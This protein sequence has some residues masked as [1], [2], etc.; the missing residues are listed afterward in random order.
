MEP[1]TLPLGVVTQTLTALFCV[2][3]DG[4]LLEAERALD[5]G[6]DPSQDTWTTIVTAAREGRIE[7]IPAPV[8]LLRT[9]GAPDDLE[10]EAVRDCLRRCASLLPEVVAE[11]ERLW[12]GTDGE[13]VSQDVARTAVAMA[14][15]RYQQLHAG[16]QPLPGERERNC[17]FYEVH[18]GVRRRETLELAA[19]IRGMWPVIL[20]GENDLLAVA[21]VHRH[22]A[23]ESQALGA[24]ED[25]RSHLAE[26]MHWTSRYEGSEQ[27]RREY[28]VVCVA[29]HLWLAGEPEEAMRRL[30][31]LEG[32]QA[33]NLLRSIEA[34]GEERDAVRK[35]ESEHARQGGDVHSLRLLALAHMDAGHTVRLD[36]VLRDFCQAH[37]DNGLAFGVHALLL[38][39]LGRFRDSAQLARRAV[40][41]GPADTLGRAILA[42]SLG[43]IGPDGREEA[44]KLAVSVIQAEDVLTA[45]LRDVLVELV[46]IAHYGGADIQ[47]TRRADELIWAYRGES[48]PPS[49][50]LGAAVARRLH[51]IV[52]EDGPAWLARLAEAGGEAP[53]ELVR[54]VLERVDALAWWETLIDRSVRAAFEKARED[55]DLPSITAEHLR[56]EAL[57]KAREKSIGQAIRAAIVLGYAEPDLDDD[58]EP[59]ASETASAL[60]WQVH[61]AHIVSL[62]GDGPAIR[63]L[64]SAI[65]QWFFFG[66]GEVDKN[67]LL[68][69]QD[70]FANERM[71]WLDWFRESDISEV[72]ADPSRLLPATRARFE[73]LLELAKADND[74]ELRSQ[75]ARGS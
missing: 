17:I 66:T 60:P 69:I 26:V 67:Q 72:L 23:G 28:G 3:H 22:R 46:D 71:V 64:A 4:F 30:R 29:Q 54:F 31:E 37:P 43:R 13:D 21:A 2:T 39:E 11:V 48:D 56:T 40:S 75:E 45:V 18:Q 10:E 61:H 7:D 14:V 42:R 38:F 73:T 41:L 57:R 9:W 58:Y 51:G 47:L 55:G 19:L 6:I 1:T 12:G 35:A 65:S 33:A 44:T 53:A 62:F 36:I 16:F 15:I 70:T 5:P 25:T 32:E 59:T 8:Q 24:H 63:L 49:E 68:V 52:S 34:R 74:G 50:W 20:R 27:H